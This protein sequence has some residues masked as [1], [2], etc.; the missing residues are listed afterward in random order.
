MQ[1]GTMRKPKLHRPVEHVLSI[2]PWIT[3]LAFREPEIQTPK[4]SWHYTDKLHAT[5][6]VL[7]LHENK[8]HLVQHTYNRQNTTIYSKEP[9]IRLMKYRYTGTN[10]NDS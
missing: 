8:L 3:L 2:E 5:L 9:Q 4:L 10:G 1:Q 7:N 6:A